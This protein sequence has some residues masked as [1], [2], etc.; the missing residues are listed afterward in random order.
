MLWEFCV[1]STVQLSCGTALPWRTVA[2]LCRSKASIMYWPP[3]APPRQ[4]LSAN[5]FKI[6]GFVFACLN[7]SAP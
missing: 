7:I 3:Y 5:I 4:P 2:K 1:Q 6:S